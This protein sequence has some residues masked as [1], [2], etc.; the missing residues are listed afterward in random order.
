M[1][2]LIA[3]LLIGA[4]LS[5][6]GT[7]V[8]TCESAMR[9]RGLQDNWCGDGRCSVTATDSNIC[10]KALGPT[11]A[12]R[13]VG[14]MPGP[15]L[16]AGA[17]EY[18][19]K[20]SDAKAGNA[21]L[22]LR[23]V[24]G[25]DAGKTVQL[26]SPWTDR[27]TFKAGLS[28]ADA[29]VLDSVEFAC[30]DGQARPSFVLGG[31]SAV[32]WGSA[33]SALKVDVETG[34]PFHLVR[35]EKGEK[36]S[37]VFRNASDRQI[38]WKATVSVE[39]YFGHVDRRSEVVRLKAGEVTRRA[40]EE[41]LSKGIR[42]VTVVAES[43][44]GTATNRLTYAHVDLHEVTPLQPKGEFRFGVNFHCSRYAPRWQTIGMD[45]AVAIGAKLVRDDLLHFSGNWRGENEFA[46]ENDAKEVDGLLSRGL[47]IDAILWWPTDWALIRD[48]D[49]GLEKSG[50]RVFRP[51]LLKRY[52]EL[53]GERYGERIAYYEVGN[54]WDMSDPK[55]LPYED[56][57]RQVREFAEGLHSKCPS[58]RVIP[59]GFAA[60]SSVR[61]P[62]GVIRP[63]F[64][65]NLMRDLQGWVS[66]HPV[67]LHGPYKEFSNKI[68]FFLQWRKEM[69]VTLPWYANETSISTTTM[70]PDDRAAAAIAWQKTLF[71]WSRGS[72]DHIWYNL[73]AVSYDRDDDGCGYGMFTAEFYPR[74][75]A[76]AYAALAS[77]FRH[78]AADGV[79]HDGRERQVLRFAGRRDGRE[80]RVVAG[81]DTFAEGPM[82]VRVRTDAARALQVDT[83][84]NRTDVLI[85]DGVAVW[86]I[87][88]H[89]S[90]LYLE[91][92]TKAEPIKA[93]LVR[94]AKRPVKVIRPKAEL[95]GPDT[96]DLLLKE[97][98][99]VYEVFKAM[100]EHVGRTWRWWG[101]L[102]VWVNTAW[103]GGKL[104]VKLTCWDDVH[105]PRPEDP[106]KG[107]CALV[108]LGDWKLLLV[109]GPNP[110]VDVKEA[111][112]GRKADATGLMS[113]TCASGYHTVYVLTV[114]PKALGLGDEIPFNVR[115][116][117]DDGP[118][119]DCW[120]EHTPFDE[121][122]SVLLK[123]TE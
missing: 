114:D 48:A 53:L 116:Y 89:P 47:A 35:R 65:E 107:D 18:V 2:A 79:L 80:V 93:D 44:G 22:T 57:V 95:G 13:Y 30:A 32:T 33:A 117:D 63:M 113:V 50:R 41:R 27:T 83:M 90:A 15:P 19:L 110:R 54:E 123:L 72:I 108:R 8:T 49:G 23:K 96:A 78:L 99:Q 52:G 81:W 34:N 106:L 105:H 1:N 73:R 11:F 74:A 100:P 42:Y 3:S 61:H 98:E 59:G 68:A 51:G 24:K 66:A 82:D 104:Q 91:G 46:W 10:V 77:T 102:W 75:T 4:S 109:G 29:Y 12:L 20:T 5:G 58:A 67:H 38:E 115:V 17:D 60:E 101:D 119:F 121:E 9:A 88:A 37:L 69:G 86:Q 103:Q 14:T 28:A 31:L 45:A 76:A 64:Q 120:I 26:S 6:D 111:P 122:P 87:S 71:G 55:W 97:Y 118:G 85:R 92:A 40:L 43:G 7:T 84:G 62:S 70:R 94:E 16:F 39:D 25:K 21:V 36:A 56:A 112:R